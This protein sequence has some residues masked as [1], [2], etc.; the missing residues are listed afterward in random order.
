VKSTYYSLAFGASL[1]DN[2]TP[3]GD[4]IM[5]RTVS[6]QQGVSFSNVQYIRLSFGVAIMH[7]TALSIYFTF[8]Y[9]IGIALF[10]IFIAFLFIGLVIFSRYLTRSFISNKNLLFS[11][12]LGKL[13][14]KKY[15][16]DKKLIFREF[17]KKFTHLNLIRGWKRRLLR[18]S[19]RF[20]KELL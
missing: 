11:R 12:L 6:E 7:L 15:R 8:F 10:S 4:T 18:D 13:K 5:T 17:L 19:M 16:I 20:L 9:Y 2:L 3:L 14:N 1:G